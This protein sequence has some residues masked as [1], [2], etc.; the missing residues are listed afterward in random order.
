MKPIGIIH[1][2]HR[3]LENMPIQPKGAAG[4]RGT[5]EIFPEYTEGLRDLDGFSHIFL[6]Y[7]FHKAA[8]TELTVVPFLDKKPRGVFAT[9]SP[10]RPSHLGLSIVNLV[11]VDGAVLT[12]EG[13][14]ILDGT[15]LYDIKPYVHRFDNV[16]D[17]TS[18]WIG[19]SDEE[20]A[21]KRSD[22]RFT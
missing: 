19:A 12:V 11:E 9:R 20:I 22:S 7:P 18:G 15:P 16:P 8:R 5:V 17:S 14:D 3:E 2:P 6:I 10:L 1:T 4:V 13:V 21:G